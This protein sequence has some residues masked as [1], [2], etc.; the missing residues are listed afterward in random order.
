MNINKYKGALVGLIV[1]DALGV[2]AEFKTRR[3]L[4]E[5]P[6]LDMVGYGTHHQPLGTWS[7]DSSMTL[8]T[9]EWLSE[10]SEQEVNYHLLMD[11]FCDWL[12]HGAYTAHNDTFDYGG[13]TCNALYRYMNQSEPLD[14]GGTAAHTNGNGSLMRILPA[15]LW[16]KDG[17]L[18]KEVKA[19]QFIEEMSALTHAHERSKLGCFLYACVVAHLYDKDDDKVNVVAKALQQAKQQC[20]LSDELKHY[21]R[22]FDIAAF[23]NL[24]E[25]EIKSSGYVVDT[26]EAALWCFLNTE[27]YEECVLKAVNLG[28][29]TDTVAAIAGGLAGLWYGFDAIPQKWLNQLVK[30]EWIEVLI[31]QLIQ[32]EVGEV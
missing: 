20:I 21:E 22:L 27:N 7:D 13:A 12:L 9:I 19:K 29:D 24:E 17:L 8:A 14:C 16:V 32:K 11:K 1:G 23:Q 5:Q 25:D 3:E 18:K 4:K 30:Y 31:H 15:A 6:I 28:D 2:P 26:L 10:L